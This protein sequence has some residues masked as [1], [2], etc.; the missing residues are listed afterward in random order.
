M[1]SL[2]VRI[3]V[4]RPTSRHWW[5]WRKWADRWLNQLLVKVNGRWGMQIMHRSDIDAR[6]SVTVPVADMA[7][8]VIAGTGRDRY[9]FWGFEFKPSISDR[10]DLRDTTL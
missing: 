3:E 4:Y 9:V 7:G 6:G 2:M 8:G 5:S 1:P 10:P